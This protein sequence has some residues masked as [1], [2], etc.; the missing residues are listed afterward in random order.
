[1]LP[2]PLRASREDRLSAAGGSRR[3]S[4]P[5]RSGGEGRILAKRYC[6]P[7]VLGFA[8]SET[9]GEAACIHSPRRGIPRWRSDQIRSKFGPPEFRVPRHALLKPSEAD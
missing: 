6:L 8:S 9:S 3:S 5:E 7:S 1:S 4:E 2:S